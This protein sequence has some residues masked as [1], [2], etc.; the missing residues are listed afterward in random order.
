MA[1]SVAYGLIK[2]EENAPESN[3]YQSANAM[4]LNPGAR[5]DAI[6]SLEIK[7]DNV[8]ATHSATVGE[9]DQDQVF[10][11]KSRGLS[12]D[13]ARHFIIL[14]FLEPMF[15]ELKNEIMKEKIINLIDQKNTKNNS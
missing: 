10:Y 2:I 4:L 7:T 5:S 11:L 1:R 13:L 9:I 3:S 15:R 6:P 12:E 8:K 14:G